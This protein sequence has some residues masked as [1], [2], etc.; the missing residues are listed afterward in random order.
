[1]KTVN[2]KIKKYTRWDQQEISYFTRR[3]QWTCRQHNKTI[4]REAQRGKK[5]SEKGR[6]KHQQI[7]GKFKVPL[8]EV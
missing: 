5:E 1:M 6:A 3:Y 4:Q 8:I 2:Y 7:V